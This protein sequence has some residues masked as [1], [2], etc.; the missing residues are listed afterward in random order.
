MRATQFTNTHT[1]QE[2]AISNT[3]RGLANIHYSIVYFRSTFLG[4][5]SPPL[6]IGSLFI[7]CINRRPQLQYTTQVLSRYEFL[8]RNYNTTRPSGLLK[9][10]LRKHDEPPS[11]RNLTRIRGD[12]LRMPGNPNQ[13]NIT[14][15]T[16]DDRSWPGG[17]LIVHTDGP[18]RN[19]QC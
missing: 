12:H 15:T 14:A 7:T 2:Q 16:Y 18:A 4:T 8:K 3:I 19:T 10:R 5:P 6:L 11:S 13:N 1:E 17:K 9:G